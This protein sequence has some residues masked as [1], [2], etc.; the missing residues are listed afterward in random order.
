MIAQA[1]PEHSLVANTPKTHEAR[2]RTATLIAQ[3]ITAPRE[4]FA[5]AERLAIID[6]FGKD[7]VDDGLGSTGNLILDETAR[8]RAIGERQGGATLAHLLGTMAGTIPPDT[9]ER[10][11]RAEDRRLVLEGTRPQPQ[12]AQVPTP[13]RPDVGEEPR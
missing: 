6:R 13:T 2:A 12:P 3:A 4:I 10:T 1:R 7:L 11:R 8:L 9:V 5:P